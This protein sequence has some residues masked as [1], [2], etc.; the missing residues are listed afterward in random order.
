MKAGAS[1]TADGTRAGRLRWILACSAAAY[2]SF[3]GFFPA[4]LPYLGVNHFGVWF[5]DSFALL[6]SNDALAR[7]LDPYAINPLDYFHRPHVYS[8]WWLHLGDLGLTRADNLRV[9]LALAGGFLAAAVGRLRPRTAA[10][11]A[12]MFT[13]LCAPP[14]LLA[15][16]RANNDLV[17]FALLAPVVPC[18]LSPRR[19]VRLIAVALVAAGAGLKYY[20][21]AG[22][23][24]LLAGGNRRD[25]RLL[26]AVAVVALGLVAIGVVPAFLRMAP[27]L[28]KADGL[29][30]FGAANLFE[31]FGMA[32]RP[33]LVSGLFAGAL[34]FAAGL[35]WRGFR[36]WK[37]STEMKPAWLS[38]VLGSVLLAGCFFTGTNYAYRWIFAIW[39]APLLW[40]LPRDDAAPV[41]V[42][43]L[44]R[45]TAALLMFALWGDAAAGA[46]LDGMAGRMPGP[47]V[48]QLADTFFRCEQPLTWALFACLLVFLAHFTREGLRGMSGRS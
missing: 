12:W 28:P 20:P 23:L 45:L 47:K 41:R 7:G 18:L 4:A 30:T 25:V 27:M 13:V 31:A 44:A 17:I 46:V 48:V 19:P 43:R 8:P 10:E 37:I 3:F 29:M 5:L 33:A 36:D 26:L 35:G 24:L 11:F 2:F 21:A 34:I 42:R 15:V 6:A 22:A 39:M 14:A 38:F 1:G 40:T 32:G 9:G 16:N